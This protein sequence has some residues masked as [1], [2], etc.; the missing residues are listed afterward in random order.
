MC[1]SEMETTSPTTTTPVSRSWKRE[2][3][4]KLRTAFLIKRE[5]KR[6]FAEKFD[7]PN[8]RVLFL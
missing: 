4:D 7:N 6:A 5:Q 2:L 8:G 1:L 3:A